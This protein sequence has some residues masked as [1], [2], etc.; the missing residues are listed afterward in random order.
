MPYPYR[1]V[2]VT[3]ATAG[4]GRALTERMIADGIFVVAVGRRGDRLDELVAKH[5]AEKV[6]AEPFDVSNLEGLPAWVER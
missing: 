3:G 2:L 5:G 1:T 6:R 4:I